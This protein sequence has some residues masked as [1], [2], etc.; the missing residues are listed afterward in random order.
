[1]KW[2]DEMMNEEPLAFVGL[3]IF[4]GVGLL[5]VVKVFQLVTP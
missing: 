2:F 1:M 5:V 4:V 3:L